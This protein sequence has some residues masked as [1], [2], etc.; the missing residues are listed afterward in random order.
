MS[1]EAEMPVEITRPLRLAFIS[2]SIA[3]LCL[4]VWAVFAPLSTTIRANGTLVSTK[5]SYDIQHSFGGRIRQVFVK[6]QSTVKK[7]QVLFE[8][9]VATQMKGLNEIK[10]QVMNI[11]AENAVISQILAAS[12][13]D[14]MAQ[15]PPNDLINARYYE[16]RQQL[17]LDISA[18][19]QTANANRKRAKSIKDGINILIK[20]RRVMFERSL[21]LNALVQKGVLS[22]AQ[23]E[24]QSDQVLSLEGE[25]SEQE[26]QLVSVQNQADQAV[27][28]AQKLKAKFRLSLL[29]RQFENTRLL[30]NLRRQL[31]ALEDEIA[32]A[33]IRSPVSGTVVFLGYDT[34]QMYATKGTTLVTLSQAL[35]QPIVQM[36][37][38]T[39]TIDQVRVG[40]AGTLTVTSLPQRNLSKIRVRLKSIS[41]DAAKDNDGNPTGYPAQATIVGDDLQQAVAGLQEDLHL[42][43]D[44][45]VS[46]TLEG[47]KTTFSQYLVAPF[48][49]MFE[50]AIQD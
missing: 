7:G 34:N 42:I 50:G 15:N 10:I 48:F 33:V 8:L 30:P 18:E 49:T 17:K 5:P 38:P 16:Q 6:A 31:L 23:E 36:L 37:I 4:M 19:L 13:T 11:E 44:M 29:S 24:L 12:D 46:V 21:S 43:A 9:D 40:M 27:L 32:S 1:H 41:P 35:D 3:I 25:I 14:K 26:E 39:Q 20:R 47:R 45:P 2:L 28:N 22:K